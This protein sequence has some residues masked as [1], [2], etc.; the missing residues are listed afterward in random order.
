MARTP[1]NGPLT[2]PSGSLPKFEAAKTLQT[3]G[4][5]IRLPCQGEIHLRIIIFRPLLGQSMNPPNGEGV[6]KLCK[7]PTLTPAT[8]LTA[9]QPQVRGKCRGHGHEFYLEPQQTLRGSENR[10]AHGTWPYPKPEAQ[11]PVPY[12]LKPIGLRPGP[13]G[14][15]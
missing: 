14:R 8:F 10:T 2:H 9:Q 6:P 4:S 12:T 5:C 3:E 1:R 11:H 13:S 15:S 7:D